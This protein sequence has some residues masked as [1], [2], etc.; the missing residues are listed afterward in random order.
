MNNPALSDQ[1]IAKIRT[2]SEVSQVLSCLEK[3][4]ET[5]LSS[6]S[7]SD[8]EQ[9]FKELPQEIAAILSASFAHQDS[10]PE[11]YILVKREIDEL[12][13]RL[14]KCESIQLTIAFKP[15]DP[16]LTLFSDWVKKNVKADTLLDLSYNA[17]IV[18]GAIL[19]AGGVFKDYS[20]RKNLA[21]RFQIQRDEIVKLLS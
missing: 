2:T 21:N 1:I 19:I 5:F 16:T 11:N 3:F 9:L 20:I 6:P 14:R 8:K 15:D 17:E 7:E 12:V 10:T 13:D 4:V 18:G